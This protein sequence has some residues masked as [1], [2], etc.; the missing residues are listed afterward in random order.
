MITF[1]GV[2]FLERQGLMLNVLEYREAINQYLL[3]ISSDFLMFLNFLLYY[4]YY[5]YQGPHLAQ[6]S[7]KSAEVEID[8]NYV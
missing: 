2:L 4:F 7:W 8:E 3:I 5:S 1:L 6:G